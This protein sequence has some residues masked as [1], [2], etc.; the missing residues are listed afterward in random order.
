M[1]DLKDIRMMF[2]AFSSV[3]RKVKIIQKRWKSKSEV[4]KA[5]I[6][7]LNTYWNYEIASMVEFYENKENKTKIDRNVM[8]KLQNLT[9]EIRA[10]VLKDY[11]FSCIKTYDQMFKNW[12]GVRD[13]VLI[14]IILVS[15]KHPKRINSYSNN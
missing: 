6:N 8:R 1:I 7:F 2:R 10:G 14:N 9:Q 5:R 11:Y 15:Q 4:N 3:D 12:Y 13:L